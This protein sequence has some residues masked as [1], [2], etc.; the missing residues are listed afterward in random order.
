[1]VVVL[2]GAAAM[3]L[4]LAWHRAVSVEPRAIRSFVPAPDRT[5]LRSIGLGAGP[6]AVSPDGSRL[7]FS[8]RRED[9]TEL[10][11]VR[12]LDSVV[13]TPLVGTEGASYPFW[14]P[15]GRSIGFFA[16]GKLKR[17]EAAGGP[18]LSLCDASNSRGGAWSPEGV[19]LFAP[20]QTSGLFRVPATGGAPLEVTRLEEARQEE[21]HRWPQFLPD[22]RK[23]IFFSR[24][25]PGDETNAV[26]AGSLDGG[27]TRVILRAQSN[28]VYASGHLLFTRET[29]LMAQP[30]DADDLTLD[31]DAFPIVEQ[32]QLDTDFSR[33]TFSVSEGGVLA[34][35]TGIPL[36]GSQLIW[37][38]RSGK[39]T[40]ILGDKAVYTDFSIS[41]NLKNVVVTVSDPQ[42]GRPPD[43]W[44]YEMARG[45]RT[46][47]TVQPRADTHPVW[48]PDGSRIV[49]SSIRK[50]N[51]DLYSKSYGASAEEELL[52][53]AEH[54]QLAESWSTDGRYVTYTSRG[55]PGTKSDIWVLPLSGEKKPIPFLQTEFREVEPQFSPDGR[56][57]AYTSDESGGRNEVY[58]APFPGP[59]RK[60]QISAA[61]GSTPRWRQDGREL[62]YLAQDNTITAVEVDQQGTTFEVGA[63]KPLFSIHPRPGTIY[64]VVPDG[65]RFLVN[66]VFEEERPSPLTLVV[67][68]T[69]DIKNQ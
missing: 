8:A 2:L 30:F 56:W 5:T 9:G 35:Q 37:F 67:N 36:T 6:V 33:G 28:A 53:E 1:V 17:I 55:V 7:V 23:F 46:R 26:M 18:A 11:W 62:C 57:I 54:D 49:F 16:A 10:L 14:S 52:L 47:F 39:Q 15:D 43:L 21:T 40:G 22:G 12:P 20:E 41:P 29:T 64:R 4:G 68:W 48:S 66:T 13:A 32:V 65:Q 44:I 69:A 63:T 60:L 34:Y 25:A 51:F 3:A 45:L 61:G 19:I 24:V 27:D 38:D 42:A 31:G 59:G 58:V 50:R